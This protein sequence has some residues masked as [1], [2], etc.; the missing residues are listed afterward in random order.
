LKRWLDQTSCRLVNSYGPTECTDV[1]AAFTLQHD[2]YLSQRV[3]PIGKPIQNVALYILDEA[4]T[5]CPIGVTG[6]L[7]IGG[8]CVG[9]GYIN[10]AELTRKQFVELPHLQQ[11][12]RFYRTGDYAKYLAD[13]NIEYVGRIDNQV[14]IRGIRIE[15]G[16]I[17]RNLLVQSNVSAAAVAVKEIAQH[18]R[19]VAYVVA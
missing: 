1:V 13:G 19:I 18:Q 5:L 16:E 11:H 4:R 6:E 2:Q 17:E 12:A 3:I 7:Y 8:D 10:D 9:P 14:K 15:I